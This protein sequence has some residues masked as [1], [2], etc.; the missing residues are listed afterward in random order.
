VIFHCQPILNVRL[1]PPKCSVLDVPPHDVCIC[2][3]CTGA[4]GAMR[5]AA[6]MGAENKPCQEREGKEKYLLVQLNV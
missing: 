5:S 4:Y 6:L 2:I 3:L 1:L